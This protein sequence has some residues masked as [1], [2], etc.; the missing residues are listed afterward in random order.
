MLVFIYMPENKLLSK[1]NI[2]EQKENNDLISFDSE[3]FIFITRLFLRIF[4]VPFSKFNCT[5]LENYNK[6]L[7]QQIEKLDV[8]PNIKKELKNTKKKIKDELNNKVDTIYSDVK[9]LVKQYDSYIDTLTP[10]QKQKLIDEIHL[11]VK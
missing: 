11:Q 10:E 3:I 2:G 9:T 8:D 5:D 6:T 4:E 7:D 1:I